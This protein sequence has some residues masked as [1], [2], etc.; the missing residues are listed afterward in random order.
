MNLDDL[1]IPQL[2]ELA[3]VMRDSTSDPSLDK[4]RRPSLVAM[5]VAGS[6]CGDSLPDREL[7]RLANGLTRAGLVSA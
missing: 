2:E 1:T 6:L 4:P 7:V 5:I 3:R